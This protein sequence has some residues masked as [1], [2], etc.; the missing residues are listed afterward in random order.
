MNGP[1]EGECYEVNGKTLLLGRSSKSDIK[2][3]DRFVSRKHLQ[4]KRKKARVFIKDLNSKNGTLVNGT[5]IR[6]GKRLEL[7]E[8]IP[9][10]IGT[11]VFCLG[12]DC[13][14]NVPAL[15]D[16]IGISEDMPPQFPDPFADPDPEND[17]TMKVI[18][19]I[20]SV[21]KKSLGIGEL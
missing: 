2:L 12:R 21:L 8:R 6:T 4:I 13:P 1:H 5:L 17:G 16:S 7:L 18:Y 15:L 11:T 14:E 9:V 20:S 10:V 19:R 3:N